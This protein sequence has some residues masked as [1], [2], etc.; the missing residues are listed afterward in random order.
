MPAPQLSN[1]HACRWSQASSRKTSLKG[2]RDS[3]TSGVCDMLL[4][5]QKL[6]VSGS[7]QSSPM[8]LLASWP[9]CSA[10]RRHQLQSLQA[11]HAVAT[12]TQ[13]LIN[14]PEKLEPQLS[15]PCTFCLPRLQQQLEFGRSS[16][17][18]VSASTSLPST[19]AQ[20]W[21]LS[22]PSFEMQKPHPAAHDICQNVS[23]QPEIPEAG[24]A[25]PYQQGPPASAG[26]YPRRTGPSGQVTC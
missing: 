9:A 11:W 19:P 10:C 24:P 25:L 23:L 21:L 4:P 26:Q 22:Y 13:H 3:F 6:A 1:L 2:S 15:V 7:H 16:P 5:P 8:Q 12:L 20:W 14:L 18:R 17:Q